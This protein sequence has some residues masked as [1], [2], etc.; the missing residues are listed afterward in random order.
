MEMED[1][2]RLRLTGPLGFGVWGYAMY[3]PKLKGGIDSNGR[4]YHTPGGGS[5]AVRST[6]V[7]R[8]AYLLLTRGNGAISRLCRRSLC[9]C[10]AGWRS[11]IR[12][13]LT[14]STST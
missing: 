14:A 5:N 8:F 13:T 2:M 12:T 10:A 3:R 9:G 7:L 11:T 1:Y 4:M 6:D